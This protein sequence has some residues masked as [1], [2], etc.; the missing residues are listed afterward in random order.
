MPDRIVQP[1]R[2]KYR[3]C[4]EKGL[5]R[6]P[7]ACAE[8]EHYGSGATNVVRKRSG[9]HVNN[10]RGQLGNGRFDLGLARYVWTGSK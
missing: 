1:T 2:A 4:W 6:L 7:Q 5:Q 8:T 3:Y 10:P 9:W